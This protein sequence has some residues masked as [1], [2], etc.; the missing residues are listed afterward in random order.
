MVGWRA[1]GL[2]GSWL[3]WLVGVMVWVDG[4]VC[5]YGQVCVSVHVCMCMHAC[6]DEVNWCSCGASWKIV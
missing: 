4:H 2:A 1:S 6:C 3:G 5:M